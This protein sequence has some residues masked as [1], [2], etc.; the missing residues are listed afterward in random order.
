MGIRILK[1]GNEKRGAIYLLVEK[2][3]KELRSGG[4]Y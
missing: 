3:F 1:N 4:V 2:P